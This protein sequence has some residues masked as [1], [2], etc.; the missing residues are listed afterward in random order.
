MIFIKKSLDHISDFVPAV[1][2]PV[3]YSSV[4][5]DK[6][7]DRFDLHFNVKGRVFMALKFGLSIW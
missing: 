5:L 2:T 7:S 4:Y 1:K 6:W 3:R